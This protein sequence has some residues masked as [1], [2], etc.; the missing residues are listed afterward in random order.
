MRKV[1]FLLVFFCFLPP[2]GLTADDSGIVDWSTVKEFFRSHNQDQLIFVRKTAYRLLVI[3]RNYEILY[4]ADISIGANPDGE[5]KRYIHDNRTPE[6]LYKV[7]ECLNKDMPVS[8]WAWNKLNDM[9]NFFWSAK[10]GHSR[11]LDPKKDL[12]TNAYGYGFYGLNYPNE[13]DKRNY[14]AA[15]RKGLI[16][17]DKAGHYFQLGGGIGIHGTNDPDSIRHNVSNGCLRLLN[18]DLKNI[19]QWLKNGTCVY[20]AH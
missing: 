10:T 9:N 1:F 3:A 8:S 18:Q 6:G 2:F 15:L 19:S 7:N 14:I 11:Y 20:I 13:M 5:P 17:K 16:P 12:G 4:G